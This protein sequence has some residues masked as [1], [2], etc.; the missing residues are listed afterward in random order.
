M[1]EAF[2]F[3]IIISIVTVCSWYAVTVYQEKSL[4]PE[5]FYSMQR[6]IQYSF[7]IQNT[8]N[9]AVRDAHLWTYAPV[10]QTSTQLCKTIESS[11]PYDL[12]PDKLGNQVLHF[13]FAEVAP[14][15]TKIVSIKAD[16]LLSDKP[17]QNNEDDLKIYLQPEKYIESGN[18]DILKAAMTL[19][20]SESVNTAENI[21]QWT[22][23]N[24]NYS[25]YASRERGALYALNYKKGDCT[26]FMYLF[27]ALC[28]ANKIPARCIG[29]YVCREN[30][31]INPGGYHNWAE[32]YDNETWKIADP[33]KKNFLNN[34]SDY[35]AWRIIA[36]TSENPLSEHN[37]FRY[38]GEGLKVKMN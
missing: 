25:G 1:K 16:L 6:H 5:A 10:K 18:Q 28:R 29:G 11:H 9:R 7:T 14:F 26:E 23:D 15:A 8:T 27:A 30:T 20:A 35:I 19:K 36:A 38:E 2:K 37:R 21:F 32:F 13:T 17:N 34:Q 31:I 3:T 12:I 22:A 4:P 24:V 33:Q